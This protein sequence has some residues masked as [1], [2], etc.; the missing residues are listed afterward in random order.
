MAKF[1][2]QNKLMYETGALSNDA[3]SAVGFL[4]LPK[5][6][7]I[8]NRRGYASTTRKGV[9][10]VYRVAL[11]MSQ[12]TLSGRASARN[13]NSAGSASVDTDVETAVGGDNATLMRVLGCQNNWVMKNAAVK[14]H[15]AREKMFRD[16]GIRKKDRGSY[17]HELRYNFDAAAQSW[18]S[19]YDGDD[20]TFTGGTW[21]VSKISY[22]SDAGFE[23]SIVGTG[24]DEESDAFSGSVLSIG[25]SYLLS[26]VTVPA[27]TNVEASETPAKHSV[28]QKMLRDIPSPDG[29]ADDD[30]VDTA[31]DEQD[32]PPY[33]LIDISDSGDV[34]HD[35][36]EPVELG[37]CIAG[38]GNGQGT[39]ICDIPFGLA[40][41]NARH[42]GAIDQTIVD[43]VAFGI[44]VLDIYPMQG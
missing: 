26:R 5:D 21:D 35:I 7:S 18:L 19:P 13:D 27:D 44:E 10:L 30:V 3:W 31:R 16:A 39:V 17:S 1:P 29:T 34:N 38:P 15:A 33:E 32:N 24:D 8:L 22:E 43:P 11:T 23:L 25:H 36:T 2:S 6:L 4:N 14:W 9:P 28:L 42:A 40:K 37:R 41:I 20:A 12:H